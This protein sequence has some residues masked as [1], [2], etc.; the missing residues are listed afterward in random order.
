MNS[1]VYGIH[2]HTKTEHGLGCRAQVNTFQRID[3]LQTSK[4]IKNLKIHAFKII[5]PSKLPVKNKK[6]ITI[7]V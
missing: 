4:N 7:E 3:I 1:P 2:K 6:E 5:H